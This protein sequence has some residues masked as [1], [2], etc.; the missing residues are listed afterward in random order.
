MKST[1]KKLS[2]KDLDFRVLSSLEQTNILGGE[3]DEA[4]GKKKKK[5]KKVDAQ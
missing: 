3:E 1:P 4:D 5:K 2:V